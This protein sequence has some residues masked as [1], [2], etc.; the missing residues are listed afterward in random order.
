MQV[1]RE[2]VAVHA[3]N[4]AKGVG[5]RCTYGPL[6]DCNPL[7]TSCY[8][9]GPDFKSWTTKN[10]ADLEGTFTRSRRNVCKCAHLCIGIM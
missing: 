4:M 2:L 9:A 5:R 3:V 6:T 1:N 8:D 10:L 7:Y